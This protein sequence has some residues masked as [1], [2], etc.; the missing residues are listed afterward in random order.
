M[1]TLNSMVKKGEHRLLT[2]L[3]KAFS[4]HQFLENSLN[5]L[6]WRLGC[7]SELKFWETYLRT[8]GLRWPEDFLYRCDPHSELQNY[9][10]DLID[11]PPGSEVRILDA[12]AGPLTSLGKRWE[13]R[14]IHITAVD[15]LAREYDRLL[16]RYHVRPPVRTTFADAE[17]LL[18]FLPPN[19]FDLV[20]AR[21]SIDHSYD[22]LLAI[23]QMIAVVKLNCFVFL[24]HV[25][26]EGENQKY[27][28]LHQWNFFTHRGD[29]LVG[30]PHRTINI[31]REFRG[32]AEVN[33]QVSENNWIV[34][35]IRK[36]G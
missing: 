24:Q 2:L 4:S 18:E 28:G 30:N 35:K 3:R 33:C 34:T 6:I 19:H 26:N 16:T 22:P 1:I 32:I 27:R 14:Q 21:N 25:I 15:P 31:T 9:I 7:P 11:A 23:Q 20:H 8:K 13:G 17:K 5:Q 29:F 10:T 12:G 36:K